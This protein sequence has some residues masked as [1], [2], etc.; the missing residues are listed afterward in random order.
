VIVNTATIQDDAA[1]GSASATTVVKILPPYRGH[2]DDV[3]V[4]EIVIRGN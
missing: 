2:R 4:N 3:E 1:S